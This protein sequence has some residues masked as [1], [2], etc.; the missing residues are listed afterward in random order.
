MR[1]NIRVFDT[2]CDTAF[3]CVNKNL[4]LRKNGLHID[5]ERLKQYGGYCQ[6]F[7]NFA[8]DDF[9][10]RFN[11][12]F[13]FIHS[14][15]EKNSD[16]IALCKNTADIEKAIAD[17]KIAA[18]ISIEGAELINCDEDRLAWAKNNGVSSINI[19]WNYANALSGTNAEKSDT[20]LTEKGKSFVKRCFDTGIAVDVS[21]ISDPA[22]W[23]VYD[24]ADGRPFIA[25]HSN[26][27]ALCSHRRNLTDEQI[28]ALISCGGIAGIN[29]Y[30]DFLGENP[31]VSTVCDHIEHFIRLGGEDNIGIGGDLD[32]CEALPEGI[33]GVQDIYKIYDMLLQRGYSEKTADKIFFGNMMRVFKTIIG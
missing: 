11:K 21:H 14:E 24:I 20:G 30:S 33:N 25:S 32:G 27:R 10:N 15:I 3:E 1:E 6:M 2:H 17:N 26:A 5:L 19:T 12:T 31:T 29:L 16:I 4:T 23:D 22:F 18:L 9:E 28:K 13:S 7:A 8:F